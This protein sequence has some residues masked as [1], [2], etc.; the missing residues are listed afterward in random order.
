MTLTSE[1]GAGERGCIATPKQEQRRSEGQY[2]FGRNVGRSGRELARGW[3]G[4]GMSLDW[5]PPPGG[6][7]PKTLHASFGVRLYFIGKI[8]Q[9]GSGRFDCA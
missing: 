2:G 3:V 8:R 7:R 5:R 6:K 1:R 9:M 4:G